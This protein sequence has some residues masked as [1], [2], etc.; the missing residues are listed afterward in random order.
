MKQ[1]VKHTLLQ[2]EKVLRSLPEG[3]QARLCPPAGNSISKA[4]QW[5]LGMPE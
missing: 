2:Y 1:L 3:D 5:V 4:W